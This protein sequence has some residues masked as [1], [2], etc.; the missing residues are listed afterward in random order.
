[1]FRENCFFE[2]KEFKYVQMQC[3]MGLSLLHCKLKYPL[4]NL[5]QFVFFEAS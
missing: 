4:L 1:M 3:P 2:A 5:F